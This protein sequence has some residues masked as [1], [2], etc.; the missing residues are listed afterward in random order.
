LN[1]SI[2]EQLRIQAADVNL[3]ESG[4]TQTQQTSSIM[5]GYDY[6]L[7]KKNADLS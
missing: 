5:V 3:V 1:S 2:F 6:F 4:G 7:M